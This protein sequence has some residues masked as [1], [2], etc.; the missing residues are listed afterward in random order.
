MALVRAFR[1]QVAAQTL[2]S[3]AH[4]EE[5]AAGSTPEALEL[6]LKRRRA[7]VVALRSAEWLLDT[8]R[9]TVEMLALLLH[10]QSGASL[11]VQPLTRNC[12]RSQ[13]AGTAAK[14]RLASLSPSSPAS[15]YPA[16]AALLPTVGLLTSQAARGHRRT[17][18][19]PIDML[20][21]DD[22]IDMVKGSH[23]CA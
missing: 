5:V 6:K 12:P 21:D 19:E 22:L 9:A 18:S 11:L 16:I 17:Q 15:R 8:R 14:P 10:L 3:V 7:V 4:E 13:G 2:P 1:T 20:M 23:W